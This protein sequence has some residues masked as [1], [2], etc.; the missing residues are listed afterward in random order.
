[1]LG[2]LPIGRLRWGQKSPS[3][4]RMNQYLAVQVADFQA[5]IDL[6]DRPS[7]RNGHLDESG[8][9]LDTASKQTSS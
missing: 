5:A 7:R 2:S 3:V 6:N 9:T 4:D 8:G 1:M